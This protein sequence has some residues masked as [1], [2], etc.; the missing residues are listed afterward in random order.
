[1]AVSM[2]TDH[3][4][5]VVEN[6]VISIKWYSTSNPNAYGTADVTKS[7]YSLVGVVG[8]NFTGSLSSFCHCSLTATSDHELYYEARMI[9]STPSSV[10][11]NSLNVKCLYRKD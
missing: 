5:Y 2:I 7:G 1:M 6:K 11:Q 9:G 8:W 3:D 10:T 4:R